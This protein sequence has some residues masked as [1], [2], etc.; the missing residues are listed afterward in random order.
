MIFDYNLNYFI[1]YKRIANNHKEN[2]KAKK[3]LEFQFLNKIDNPLFWIGR[4]TKTPGVIDRTEKLNILKTDYVPIPKIDKNFNKSF[5]EICYSTANNYWDMYDDVTIFWS[6]GLDSTCLTIAMLETKP[7]GKKIS[8]VGT[9]ES[10]EEYPYFYET[11]KNIIKIVETQTFWEYFK[12]P[13]NETTYITG[14]CCDQ[15]FGGNIDEFLNFKNND[16]DSFIE[17][18]DPFR[19]N[20]IPPAIPIEVQKK[21]KTPWAKIEKKKFL[22]TLNEFNSSAPFKVKTIFDFFSWVGF[23]VGYM[24]SSNNITKYSTEILSLE[25]A[26]LNSHIRFFKTY[27]F[28]Q[29]FLNNHLIKYPGAENTYKQP[30]KTFIINYN[31]DIDFISSKKKENSTV[32]LL[33]KNFFKTFIKT[34]SSYYLIMKNSTIYSHKN[35]IPFETMVSTLKF[36]D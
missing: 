11:H 17:W 31:K 8:I 29:W 26:N 1:H 30:I 18:K 27:D 6:G 2:E 10:I 16:W 36:L 9:Q 22:D 23:A 3:I 25:K 28:Q 4:L 14:C 32:K 5:S 7:I 34:D 33:N 24:P 21:L 35:D 13:Q 20:F 15:I 19:T 12:T